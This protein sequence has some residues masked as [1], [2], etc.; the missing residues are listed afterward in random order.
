MSTPLTSTIQIR[1]A[2]PSDDTTLRRLAAL[3]SHRPLR[4]RALIA[5]QD[6]TPLA[7]IAVE[8]GTVVADP[9]ARTAE[10]V[11]L[12]EVHRR[13]GAAREAR[14]LR[15]APTPRVQLGLAA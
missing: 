11:E 2:A 15:T 8:D 5:E 7:A 4:G 6:G 1:P 13:F 14:A 10:L 3:D 9:F 12:L